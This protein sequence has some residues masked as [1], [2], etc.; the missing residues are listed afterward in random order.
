VG[1]LL[2]MLWMLAAAPAASA[3]ALETFQTPLDGAE[4]A[5]I[6]VEPVIGNLWLGAGAETSNLAEA[7]ISL[8]GSEEFVRNY[9]VVDGVGYYEVKT[10]EA[11]FIG[12]PVQR[13]W[14]VQ[15][16]SN[17][18][19]DVAT[20]VIIGEQTVNFSGLEI[21]G[22]E[23]ETIIGKTTLVLP[24]GS[25]AE[26]DS[27]VII[28]EMVVYLL[29][30]TAVEIV[31]DTGLASVSHPEDFIEEG[32]DILYSPSA[33]QVNNPLVLRVNLPIGSLRIQY[34]E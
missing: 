11:W 31:L 33:S 21:V 32:N 28:G 30:D 24:S 19:L 8:S 20:K 18:P 7:E 5:E 17:L 25:S 3:G 2:V 23:Q 15:V 10:T 4:E 12:S 14:K 13:E 9:S 1:V 22:S 16:N 29:P 34:V 6:L 26:I 27:S